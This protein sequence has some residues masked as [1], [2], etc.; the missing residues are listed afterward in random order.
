LSDSKSKESAHDIN[1]NTTLGTDPRDSPQNQKKD[2][3]KKL[4]KSFLKT[5][6]A[7]FTETVLLVFT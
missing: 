5:Q 7:I 1:I 2:R 6:T 4:F 3:K